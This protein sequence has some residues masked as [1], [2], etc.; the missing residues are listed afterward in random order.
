[1]KFKRREQNEKREIKRRL[2][3]EAV[4]YFIFFALCFNFFFSLLLLFWARKQ[5]NDSKQKGEMDET[6]FDISW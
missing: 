5:K 6:L 1:M 3:G 2:G 4:F